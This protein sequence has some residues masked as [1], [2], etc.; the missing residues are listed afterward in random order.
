MKLIITQPE[1][2]EILRDHVLKNVQ[3]KDGAQIKIDFTATRGDDGIT[4]SIDIPYIGTSA[5]DLTP[6][7]ADNTSKDAKPAPTPKKAPVAK[8][9]AEPQKQENHASFDL[10]NA[11]NP[12]AGAP[13]APATSGGIFGEAKAAADAAVAPEGNAGDTDGVN[14]PG[15]D[16]PAPAGPSLFP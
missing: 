2:S 5:L 1:I 7:A 15:G 16:M 11:A 13:V 10:G 4:A 8:P 14:T 3:L 6:P 12:N 9:P